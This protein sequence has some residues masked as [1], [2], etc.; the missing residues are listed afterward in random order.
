MVSYRHTLRKNRH[1]LRGVETLLV[2]PVPSV[3]TC[4]SNNEF[5][6]YSIQNI[7]FLQIRQC[8]AF[9]KNCVLCVS[10]TQ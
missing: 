9:R 10:E 2:Q 7:I 1:G 4:S 5:G 6:Y 8:S 3:D